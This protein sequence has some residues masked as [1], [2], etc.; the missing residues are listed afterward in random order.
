MLVLGDLREVF[1]I[2]LEDKVCGVVLDFYNENR[3]LMPKY[4]TYP[5]LN[6]SQ[7]YFNSGLL[8]FN[9]SSFLLNCL[10]NPIIVA[11]FIGIDWCE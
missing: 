5:I 8:L 11:F 1:A 2:D 10:I 3:K 4:P 7:S 9:T 6:L